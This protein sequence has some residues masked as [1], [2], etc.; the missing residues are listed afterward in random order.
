M[1]KKD[2]I[3]AGGCFWCVEHDLR[4]VPGVLDAVS[5]YAGA[6][7]AGAFGATVRETP[8]YNNHNGYREAVKVIYD[9]SITSFKKL[10]Q[11]FLDHIDPTDAE[12]QFHDRG[13]SYQTAIFYK[14][15]EEKITA[16]SLLK[17]LAESGIYDAPIAVQI[18][19]EEAFYKAE[20]YHQK[21]AEKNPD[22]YDAY[23]RGSGRAD[24]VGRVCMVRDE[25]KITWKD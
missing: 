14:S 20:E 19:P 11:F 7:A 21:Y 24:F 25:K 8:N 16:E 3:F 15:E 4:E 1:D 6:A 10:C 2:A 5:G 12:G 17:E 9:P 18:L 22:H 23:R 13:A